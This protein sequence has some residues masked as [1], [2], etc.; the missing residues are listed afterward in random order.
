MG[1]NLNLKLTK[2]L[3]VTSKLFEG[4]PI[5]SKCGN[6]LN[7]KSILLWVFNF[8]STLSQ[9]TVCNDLFSVSFCVPFYEM[10]K[11]FCK[12]TTL[13]QRTPLL[14][15]LTCMCCENHEHSKFYNNKYVSINDLIF[16]LINKKKTEL[17]S[18]KVVSL[19]M[20]AKFL[21]MILLTVLIIV[22]FEIKIQFLF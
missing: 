16:E 12:K 6:W 20:C 7:Q 22:K 10:N 2:E 11:L 19:M 9:R 3:N 14:E 4:F 15:I 13:C 1:L 18:Y 17:A 5:K 21:W 8:L